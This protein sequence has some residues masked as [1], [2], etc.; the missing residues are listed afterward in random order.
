MKKVIFIFIAVLYAF[1]LNAQTNDSILNKKIG[2]VGFEGFTELK[3]KGILSEKEYEL[4]SKNFS[5]LEES[6]LDINNLTFGQ[7]MDSLNLAKKQMLITELV[8]TGNDSIFIRIPLGIKVFIGK[9]EMSLE[10]ITE[11]ESRNLPK[12]YEIKKLNESINDYDE[13]LETILNEKIDDLTINIFNN[14]IF[15]LSEKENNISK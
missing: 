11:R 8:N 1:D 14:T 7:L 13:P 5:I 4:F 10:K 2:D 9:G 12:E 15:I 3:N 6:G